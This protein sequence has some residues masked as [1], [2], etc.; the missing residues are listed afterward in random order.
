[1]VDLA[2]QTLLGSI[3]VDTTVGTW[4]GNPY[5]LACTAGDTLVFT[6]MDQWNDLKL[7]DA[8]TGSA[9]DHTGSLYEPD[10]ASSP[11]GTTLY[12]GEYSGL[13]GVTR[14]DIVNKKLTAVDTSSSSGTA[15]VMVTRDDKYVFYSSQKLLAANLK[16]VVGTFSETILAVNGDGTIAVGADQIFDGTTFA[17]KRPLPL[18]TKTMAMSADGSTLYLYD[19]TSSRI[20]IYALQ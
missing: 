15:S 18:S 8:L 17:V 2:T 16:S 19:T 12:A 11:D 4:A 20:Y 14:Y 5:R 1:M 6:S 10:L 13:S 7:V 3:F 9:L